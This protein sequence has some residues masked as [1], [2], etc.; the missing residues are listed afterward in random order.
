MA[1]ENCT[2]LGVNPIG[3]TEGSA[4]LPIGFPWVKNRKP[5]WSQAT[6]AVCWC[7]VNRAAALGRRVSVKL[8]GATPNSVRELSQPSW[9][10]IWPAPPTEPAEAGSMRA[11]QTHLRPA[12]YWSPRPGVPGTSWNRSSHRLSTPRSSTIPGT[13]GG[14]KLNPT[15]V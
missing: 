1:T 15:W 3:W 9:L 10:P 8:P 6:L 12:E 14:R 7:A 2:L 11:Y 13:P 4:I 5:N